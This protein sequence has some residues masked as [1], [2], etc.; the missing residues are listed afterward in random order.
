MVRR[1]NYR[2][3]PNSRS[4]V[5]T[6]LRGNIRAYTNSNNDCNTSTSRDVAV[7][8]HDKPVSVALFFQ[9]GII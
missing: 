1:R 2:T 3:V 9:I 8:R 5:Q 6:F 7:R 4:F